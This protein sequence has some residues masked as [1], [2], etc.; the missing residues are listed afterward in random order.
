MPI[1]LYTAIHA[2][3]IVGLRYVYSLLKVHVPV[4]TSRRFIIWFIAIWVFPSVARSPRRASCEEN[5]IAITIQNKTV[6]F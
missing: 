5:P 4:L 3:T 2:S 1:E 6:M